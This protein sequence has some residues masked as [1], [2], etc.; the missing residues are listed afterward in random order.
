MPMLRTTLL[1]TALLFPVFTCQAEVLVIDHT[2]QTA[3]MNKPG[4]G[5]TMGDVEARFGAPLEKRA[6][7]GEPPIAQWVY[8]GFIVYFEYDRVIHSVA[9]HASQP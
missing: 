3:T 2:Q 1:A 9:R 6:A 4:N 8:D 7:V 5:M